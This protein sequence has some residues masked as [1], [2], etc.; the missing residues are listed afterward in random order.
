MKQFEVGKRYTTHHLTD[1][2]K[3]LTMTVFFRSEKSIVIGSSCLDNSQR[4]LR[5][6]ASSDSECVNAPKGY[7]PF[8]AVNEAGKTMEE[9][10]LDLLNELDVGRWDTGTGF[11]LLDN[12]TIAER[13]VAKGWTLPTHCQECRCFMEYTEEHKGASG[14]ADGDCYIRKMYSDDEQFIA[15][16][17][18]DYCSDG[19]PKEDLSHGK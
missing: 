4:R 2:N 5:Y 15:R 18:T 6:A 16:K 10:L 14:D 12:V 13:I 9:K 7:A 19:K 11:P 3:T 17:Y 1:P 8:E